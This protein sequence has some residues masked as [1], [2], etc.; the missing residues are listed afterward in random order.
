M[1]VKTEQYNPGSFRDPRGFLYFKD[2]IIYRQVNNVY[3]RNYDHLID[4][5]KYKKLTSE[6]FLVQHSEV[7]TKGPEP[8]KA[9]KIIRTEKIKYSKRLLYLMKKKEN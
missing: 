5:A 8:E 2:G 3:S 6:K 4:S 7:N 9:Y 1:T